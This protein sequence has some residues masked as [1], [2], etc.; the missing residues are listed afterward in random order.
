MKI[1]YGCGPNKKE[2][3][4]GVD[5]QQFTKDGKDVVDH[6]MDIGREKWPWA[7]GSIEEA[8][9]A[10]FI[11]HLTWP[12]RI[13]FF[14]ELYRVL[15]PGAKCQLIFPHWNSPR[16]YGDPTHK[17]PLSE[18]AFFYLLKSWRDANAPHAPYTCDFETG[19]GYTLRG[20]L[21]LRNQEYQQFALANYKDAAQDIVATLTRRA[22]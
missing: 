15:A 21:A 19:Y 16:F 9:A 1:D 8:H 7:D 12:E 6:V 11:E 2:G 14:N 20:D 5:K 13:H 18:W 22:P 3:F 4:I 10:H 17:E